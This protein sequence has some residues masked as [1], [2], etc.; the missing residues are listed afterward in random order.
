MNDTNRCPLRLTAVPRW[1]VT[2][3]QRK[4]AD[5]C[6]RV[7]V[8]LCLVLASMVK[9]LHVQFTVHI[10]AHMHAVQNVCACK[11]KRK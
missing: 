9:I 6:T 8:C 5:V 10:C 4:R 7:C 1:S 11:G 3:V 2:L